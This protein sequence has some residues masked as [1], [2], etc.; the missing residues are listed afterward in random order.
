MGGKRP[1]QVRMDPPAT[2]FKTRTPDEH[3]HEEDKQELNE[4]PRAAE[5]RI[6]KRGEN[7][8]K[9]ELKRHRGRSS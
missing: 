6:P 1:D 7:P 8:A 3:I 4:E 5:G 2:D 9:S